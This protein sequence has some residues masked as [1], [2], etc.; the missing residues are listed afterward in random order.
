MRSYLTL[1][2][3]ALDYPFNRDFYVDA[4]EGFNG[5]KKRQELF[6]AI[7]D[8]LPP[9]A[10]VETGTF[11]GCT[12]EFMSRIAACPIHT[13]EQHPR[14]YGYS[15]ARLWKRGNV[16]GYWMDTLA[17]LRTKAGELLDP[18]A[19][20]FFYLDAHWESFLPL[21]DELELIFGRFRRAVIMIDDFKVP[22]DPGYRFDAYGP[23]QTLDLDY[24][25]ASRLPALGVY[26]P[27]APAADETGFKRG[28]CVLAL[29]E[30]AEAIRAMDDLSLLR[31]WP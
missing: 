9:A 25:R 18:M 26:F 2:H 30:D 31:R 22:D 28:A 3:G 27:S 20:T 17:F 10:I 1:I 12:T 14:Y 4:A 24:V 5:Q 6:C 11:R 8:R 13:V 7:V 21:R 19:R 29:K 16:H 15:R 23:E